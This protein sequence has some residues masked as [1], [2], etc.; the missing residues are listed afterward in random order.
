MQSSKP[1]HFYLMERQDKL[2]L[3]SLDDLGISILPFKSFLNAT[4]LNQAATHS[5]FPQNISGQEE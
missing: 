4:N 5:C 1:Y 2:V 3:K